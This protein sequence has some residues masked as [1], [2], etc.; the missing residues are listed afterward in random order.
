MTMGPTHLRVEH[1]VAPLG[2]TVRTP[3]LSWR[4]PLGTRAQ[5]AYEVEVDGVA[6]GRVD[7]DASV[8]VPWPSRPLGTRQQ[9]SWRVRVWTDGRESE[10]STPARFETG[11]LGPA[12][13][14]ARFIEPHEPE[15]APS[16]QRPAHLLRHDFDVA[17]PAAAR[18]YATAHGIYECFL[19]GVRVG[20]L[21]LTPGFTA[22]DVHLHVQAYDVTDLLRVGTN[23]W[24]VVLSDGWFRGRTGFVQ[25]AD[26]YGD[27]VAFLGQLHVGDV[28]VGTGDGWRSTTGPIVA[29]DLM[30]G[31]VEDR[32]GTEGRWHPVR[33]VDHDLARLSSSPAPPTRR[34]EELRP[35][36]VT[37]P[38]VDRQVVDLG[39]NINGWVRLA[40]LGPEGT[41]VSLVHG[42]ALD[43]KGDVTQEHLASFD[44]FTHEPIGVGMTDRVT[45]AGR[46]HDVFEPRHTTHGFQY[47]RVEGHPGRLTP[48]DVTGIVVHTDMRRTGWF[49]CS[50]E[51][52]NRFHDATVWSFRG[53]ACEVP[54]D[55][56]QRERAGWTGDYQVF[57]PTAAFLYDVAGFSRKW[58]QDVLA[59]ARPDGCITN[60]SPDPARPQALA[61]QAETWMVMQGSSGWGDAI[62]IVP[63]ELWRAYAD[64][65]VL[66]ECWPAMVAWVG[67]AERSARELRWPGRV[68][69]SLDPLAHEAFL[70]DGGFHWGEWLE[71]GG[72]DAPDQ[73]TKDKGE[74]GTAFLHRSATLAGRVGRM[75]GHHE[76]ADRLTELAANA[77]AAWRA[78]YIAADG[79]LTVDTQANHVRA[80]AFGLI[81]DELRSRTADRLVTLVR[82]AGTHLGTG[83]LATPY[84][85]PVLADSGNLD[86]A[87]EL[88]LQD[89]PPSWLAMIDRGATTV[90]EQWEGIDDDGDPHASLNHYSK[91]AV[92]QFLHSHTAGIQLLDEGPAYRRFRVAPRPGGGLT[93]AEAVHDSPYGRIESSWRLDSGRY[94]LT[95]T[96]PPGT[97]AEV[98]LPDGARAD[99]GPGRWTFEW[100]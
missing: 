46:P 96:V 15:R 77:L 59:D 42:E 45:T 7:S 11:L 95:V 91:G 20:D 58:L 51:R 33:V 70:W 49:R 78:E 8:L 9:V 18:L 25:M 79:S 74:I 90:W 84:L 94:R 65:D 55:C 38:T 52:V 83:F 62:T 99:A 73:W 81:P 17:D 24:E 40:D 56:P 32:R 27:A 92:I 44:Y 86:V 82:E 80:L 100:T 21:E 31:Q 75:L 28:V 14:S 35:V 26:A 10:W 98:A 34:I 16:G 47:V 93:W 85:L 5:T 60:F 72:E 36:S 6:T 61:A 54:T 53:N 43:Q 30:T 39:Q 71:P 41:V 67:F 12:D 88:L 4:L 57:V 29:A 63:W 89:T 68:E 69:R 76:E 2:T 22:Y 66:A 48:D 87:Y 19:N 23:T 1:L 13:W 97:T 3:R 64:H 37:R 50:D